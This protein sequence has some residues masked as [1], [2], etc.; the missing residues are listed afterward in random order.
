[1]RTQK[2]I[3]I[4]LL[5]CALLLVVILAACDTRGTSAPTNDST[6]PSPSTRT[7][8]PATATP[9][10]VPETGHTVLVTLSEFKITSSVKTFH[11]GVAYH[12][13]ITN[14][15]NIDHELMIVSKSLDVE[16]MTMDQVHKQALLVIEDVASGATMTIN[17]TIPAS[18][19]GGHYEMACHF[20]DHY[21][22]G[23]HLSI[24]IEK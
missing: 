21:Q 4:A 10:A 19:L 18:A 20:R 3:G 24:K 11:A 9:T 15:G 5:L 16:A 22:A 8:L 12:F 14:A 6:T 23:M 1:M 17:Y 7:A 13:V 2:T